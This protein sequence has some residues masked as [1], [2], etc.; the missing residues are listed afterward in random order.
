MLLSLMRK[1]AKSWLIKFLI[2]IIA[3]VFIFYFGYSASSREGRKVAFVNGEM[4]SG[5]E[6][7]KA[8]RSMLEALQRE[9]KS[10]WSDGLVKAFNIK[11][12]ALDKLITQK[13]VSQ[14]AKRIGLEVTEK[15][16]QNEIM[17]NPAFQFKGRFDESRYRSLLTNN[18]MKP[19]DFEA[20][21][22]QDLLQKKVGQ[23]LMTFLPVTDQETLDHYAFSNGKVK[24]GFVKF[25]SEQF[26]EAVQT[27]QIS[28]EKY[29]KDHREEYRI[30]DKIKINY[31]LIDPDAF[32]GKVVIKDQ[33]MNDYYEDYIENFKQKKQVK[34]RHI[35]FKLA[36]DASKE[37]EKKVR[38]KA[39]PVLEK[40]RKGEDFIALAKEYSEGPTAKEGGDL[41]YFSQGQ[42]VKP[43]EEVAFK[44]KKG[45]I[46]DL[47]RTD[48]G[49]HIIFLDDI[50]EARTKSL[51]EVRQVI[52]KTLKG[53]AHSDLA[54]EK[55]LSMIDQM[56]YDVELAKYAQEH[57]LSA[58]LTDY[59]AQSEPI[60]G[61][62]G[63]EKLRKS[64]FS[65]EKNDISELIEFEDKFYIIQV[66][67]KKTST[68]PELAEVSEKVKESFISFLAV[69][70]AKSA[71]EVYL[72]RLKGGES[73]EKLAKEMNLSPE[74]TELF[75]R[76]DYIS[77]I[78]YSPELQEAAF[79]TGENDQYPAKVFETD[80][81][82]FVIRWEGEEGIDEKKY[83]KEKEKYRHSL[84]RAKHQQIFQGWL[85]KLKI[86]ADIEI[87]QP[88]DNEV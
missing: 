34:A 44:M 63:D 74:T 60:P 82:V 37:E 32:E 71:A 6:Y 64:L 33:Q 80:N 45:E 57:G 2:G 36:R 47:V 8:Y 79:L 70:K 19:E 43:F 54:H 46:S 18:R 26:K 40:A 13:L 15:E 86:K 55:A 35:L 24:I 49:F 41:G 10:V 52:E 67:D 83:Q 5:L 9:Y 76:N 14:E 11:N 56:P 50:K 53:L 85:E 87:L 66:V 29:F 77:Q 7:D 28:L 16:I 3:L 20:E 38:E 51:E 84:M 65:L 48:F 1:H 58:K 25:L 27:D 69:E 78:G 42:M 81:G 59:F 23:L 73:W 31:I 39:S 12:R 75:T 17:A 68:L 72:G 22:A 21:F 61:I 88:F 30:P 62:K 4:I